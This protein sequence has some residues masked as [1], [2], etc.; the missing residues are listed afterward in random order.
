MFLSLFIV[1]V[2]MVVVGSVFYLLC[3]VC[4]KAEAGGL[5]VFLAP[6]TGVQSPHPPPKKKELFSVI[7]LS[8]IS[9]LID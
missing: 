3:L 1:L 6:C 9:S 5:L 7:D 4:K 8:K 2:L